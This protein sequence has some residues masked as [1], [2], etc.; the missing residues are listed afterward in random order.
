M[1]QLH[2]AQR[3]LIELVDLRQSY[4]HQTSFTEA[5]E[6]L[7]RHSRDQTAQAGMQRLSTVTLPTIPVGGMIAWGV[8]PWLACCAGESSYGEGSTPGRDRVKDR[9]FPML[10]SEIIRFSP[11]CL[12][13]VGSYLLFQYLECHSP[14]WKC[15]PLFPPP[16]PS[17]KA[18]LYLSNSQFMPVSVPNR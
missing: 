13:T 16:P 4:R 5:T 18:L 2:P 9:Y 14:S 1:S 17:F 8:A 6:T 12:F 15:P 7:L 10:V 11:P 3:R